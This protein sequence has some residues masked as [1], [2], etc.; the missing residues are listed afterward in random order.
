MEPV[1][2]RAQLVWNR[3]LMLS[4]F[5]I[6]DIWRFRSIF[7]ITPFLLLLA[8][9][10][11]P[12]QVTQV[13]SPPSVAQSAP[14]SHSPIP[15]AEL[16]PHIKPSL[17]ETVLFADFEH[18]E[19]DGI[20]L[21]FINGKQSDQFLSRQDGDFYIKLE[22]QD[23]SG[24]WVRAQPHY[25]SDC[26]NSYG[27][28]NVPPAMHRKINGYKPREGKAVKVRYRIYAAPWMVSNEGMGIVSMADAD[29]AAKDSMAVRYLPSVFENAFNDRV[30][31]WTPSQRVDALELLQFYGKAT[32]IRD[33]AK[34]L[35]DGWS[36]SGESTAEQ[37]KAAADMHRLL[38]KPEPKD[39]SFD[40]LVR[41]CWKR[42]NR[43]SSGPNES[44][45]PW[46]VCE[47]LSRRFF[48]EGWDGL[49]EG[50]MVSDLG[51][52]EA[53]TRHAA[54]LHPI[55][56]ES[57]RRSIEELLESDFLVDSFL[58]RDDLV[59][60]LNTTE[61]AT[62]IVSC[63][64][65][66]R[67]E[68]EWLA[69][70]AMGFR[71]EF[72]PKVVLALFS[73]GKNWEIMRFR[74]LWHPTI[75][76]KDSMQERLL[77]DVLESNPSELARLLYY[78]AEDSPWGTINFG[79]T[80]TLALRRHLQKEKERKEEFVM[81][82]LD[83][84]HYEVR[85]LALARDEQDTPLLQALL[86]HGGYSTSTGTSYGSGNEKSEVSYVGYG[87]RHVAAEMLEE[88]GVKVPPDVV[89]STE[90]S[91]TGTKV[92]TFSKYSRWNMRGDR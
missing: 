75:P 37:K 8:S 5:S 61:Q 53:V 36:K 26:G 89:V 70:Q 80:I 18:P 20:P 52:W 14:S 11:K 51:T 65:V 77:K 64:F 86:A 2:L 57:A 69:E 7:L 54:Q 88:R 40:R 59:K 45:V 17:G 46:I 30:K 12:P 92:S 66:R 44:L 72:K 24:K 56:D 31:D 28:S 81:P 32:H 35:A 16:P 68:S 87:I 76:P 58:K 6:P 33:E 4:R 71:A 3:S 63:A 42:I 21:Y 10:K 38:S 47:Q 25:Y 85:Y 82:P 1:E 29:L 83:L 74:G 50:G 22:Y 67:G 79:P 41:E 48:R 62:Y 60:L 27:G 78:W 34:A 9:C 15:N 49:P 13:E 90:T 55:A 39:Q 91:S 23:V 43:Q 19:S 73:G 84:M